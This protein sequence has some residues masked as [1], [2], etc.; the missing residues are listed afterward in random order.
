MTPWIVILVMLILGGVAVS[1]PMVLSAA[2]SCA[3][4]VVK[5]GENG[6]CVGV[7]D[8]S[9]VFDP[10]LADVERLIKDENDQ[11]LSAKKPYVTVGFFVQMTLTE[12]DTVP[13][14]WV[15]HQLQGAY[16]A[17]FRA[18]H[19]HVAGDLP[20][21][22][23]LLVNPGTEIALWEPAITELATRRAA[24]DNLVAVAGMGISTDNAR[25][26]MRRLAEMNVLMLGA[27]VTSDD[28]QDIPLLLRMAPTNSGQAK[29][30][31]NYIKPTA[32]T[33]MLVQDGS[34]NDLYPATLAKSFADTFVDEQ[35]RIL[36]QT[37]LYDSS[38][39]SVDNTFL[40]MIPNICNSKPQVVYFAGRGK[41]LASFVTQL[42]G[43][44]CKD[45]RITVLTGDDVSSTLFGQGELGRALDSGVQVV[46]TT[47]AH[48]EAWRL[49]PQAFENA[50]TFPFVERVCSVCFPALFPKDTL[51]DASAIMSYDAV[52]TAA[53][54]IRFAAGNSGR[55][56][57]TAD[58]LQ[59]KNRLHDTMSVPGA[60]GRLSFDE[61]GTAVAKAV[62]IMTLRPNGTLEFLGLSSS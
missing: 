41:H 33:A 6:E 31:A 42:T 54:A 61:R 26:A 39:S 13:M 5:H 53:Y 27:T 40:Q 38:L 12:N 22:R 52:L 45:H 62:P 30:A 9:Y 49:A 32:A 21:V 3:D 59:V 4:G 18:N 57:S 60:S 37:E 50:A 23:L 56:V 46:F 44:R 19:H 55:V 35:H 16:L 51:D 43:R 58:L 28:L 10:D 24:P 20:L 11:V 15:R 14:S 7:T 34:K 8:G 17:Q 36:G 29:A 2:S 25:K 1:V 48:P 47:L